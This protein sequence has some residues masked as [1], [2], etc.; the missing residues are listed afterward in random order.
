MSEYIP[1][2]YWLWQGED[3][4]A[5]GGT[6]IPGTSLDITQINVAVDLRGDLVGRYFDLTLTDK[7]NGARVF[8]SR[9]NTLD[10]N[11]FFVG[12]LSFEFD[13]FHMAQGDEYDIEMC[14]NDDTNMSFGLIGDWTP[15]FNQTTKTQQPPAARVELYGVDS[16][17]HAC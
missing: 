5:S 12:F 3:C 10:L 13:N 2:D 14:V 11:G 6:I 7:N 15:K 4:V 8:T 17:L 9:S 1:Q 16:G